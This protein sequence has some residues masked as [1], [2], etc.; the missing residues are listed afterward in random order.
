M[1]YKKADGTPDGTQAIWVAVKVKSDAD[2]IGNISFDTVHGN[3][4]NTH[5]N[6]TTADPASGQIIIKDTNNNDVTGWTFS[7]W[8]TESS[9]TYTDVTASDLAADLNDNNLDA[10][11]GTKDVNNV[12]AKITLADGSVVHTPVMKI[13]VLGGVGQETTYTHTTTAPNATDGV[14]NYTAVH[15]AFSGATYSWVEKGGTASAPTWSDFTDFNTRTED[16]DGNLAANDKVYVKI[17]WGDGTYQYVKAP[18][19][20][21]SDADDFAGSI[22]NAAGQDILSH[23]N[24]AVSD[25]VPGFGKISV[26]DASNNPLAENTNT[27]GALNGWKFAGWVTAAHTPATARD[28]DLSDADLTNGVKTVTAYAKIEL[29]DGS[30]VYSRDGLNIKVLGGYENS[31][32]TTTANG[33]SLTVDQAQTA[34]ANSSTLNTNFHASGA[35]QLTYA[36]ST[37]GIHTGTGYNPDVTYNANGTSAQRQQDRHAYVII[38]YGDGTTQAVKVGYKVRSDADDYTVAASGVSAITTHVGAAHLA[39]QLKG[40]ITLTHGTSTLALSS[41]TGAS[42]DWQNAGQTPSLTAASAE[43]DYNA[44]ITFADGSKSAAIAVPVTV[45]GI[46]GGSL[47][48]DSGEQPGTTN[49]IYESALNSTDLTAVHAGYTTT[50]TW[51]ANAEGDALGTTGYNTTW[52]SSHTSEPAYI[53]VSYTNGAGQADGAEVVKV[54][55]NLTSDADVYT[56][57]VNASGITTHVV[58][59]KD[60]SGSG[61]DPTIPEFSGR[62]I[63]N[64][65]SISGG[66]ATNAHDVISSITWGTDRGDKPDFSRTGSNENAYIVLHYTDGSTSDRLLLNVNVVGGAKRLNPDSS[67]YVTEIDEDT[68]YAKDAD[69]RTAQAALD[70]ATVRAITSYNADAKFSWAKDSEDESQLDTSYNEATASTNPANRN[71]YVIVTYHDGTKQAIEVPIKIKTDADRVTPSVEPTTPADSGFSV[72]ATGHLTTH[73]N[74]LASDLTPDKVITLKDANNNA[75]TLTQTADGKY[76]NTANHITDVKWNTAIDVASPHAEADHVITISF[77][78][79]TS[80]TQ[81]IPVTVLGFAGGGTTTV[82]SGQQPAATDAAFE[83]AMTSSD[84]TALS[85]INAA[86]FGTTYEWVANAN[87]DALGTT[88]YNTLYSSTHTTEPAYIKVTYHQGTGASAASDGSQVIAVTLDLSHRNTDYNVASVAGSSVTVHAVNVGTP[89][90]AQKMPYIFTNADKD[91]FQ[92]IVA[93]THASDGSAVASGDLA[94]LIDHIEWST[95]PDFTSLTNG[96]PQTAQAVIHFV[97][98]S[99]SD[100]FNI[101]VNVIGGEADNTVRTKI[102]R[103]ATAAAAANNEFKLDQNSDKAKAALTNASIAALTPT[104]GSYSYPVDSYTWAGDASDT[105]AVDTSWSAST[106]SSNPADRTAYVILHYHDGSKQ[107]VK[108]NIHINS[109]AERIASGDIT[110]QGDGIYQ[111]HVG[112]KINDTL[113]E[114]DNH[115]NVDLT[116]DIS[117]RDSDRNPMFV[118][119]SGN[120]TWTFA[121]FAS[122]VGSTYRP[123]NVDLDAADLTDGKHDITNLY[124]KLTLPDGSTTYVKMNHVY[125][126]GGYAHADDSDGTRFT[127]VNNGASLTAGQ[128][129]AAIANN[130][131]LTDASVVGSL[132]QATSFTWAKDTTGTALTAADTSWRAGDAVSNLNRTAYVIIGY[133][134]NTK[135]AVEDH[136]DVRKDAEMIDPTNTGRYNANRATY[137]T[138]VGANING[139]TN[140]GNVDLKNA[141]GF[142]DSADHTLFVDSSGNPTWTFAGFVKNTGTT[143]APVYAAADVDLDAADLTN[144]KNDITNLYAKVTL[145][146]G[147]I[148][149]VPLNHVYVYGGYEQKTVAGGVTTYPTATDNGT[150][151]TDDEARVAIANSGDLDTNFHATGAAHLTYQWSTGTASDPIVAPD[152]AYDANDPAHDSKLRTANVIITYGDGTKQAVQVHYNVNSDADSTHINIDPDDPAGKHI[153]GDPLLAHVVRSGG[154]EE[155][156]GADAIIVTVGSGSSAVTK[157]LGDI[158]ATIA[159]DTSA[160]MNTYVTSA[161]ETAEYKDATITYADHSTKAVQIRVKVV[162]ASRKLAIAAGVADVVTDHGVTPTAT[163]SINE[164]TVPTGTKWKI[165][166]VKWAD[167]S[168]NVLTGTDLT[169]FFKNNTDSASDI[170]VDGTTYHHAKLGYILVSYKRG[171]NADGSQLIAL[172][173]QIKFDADN[174]TGSIRVANGQTI[175]AHAN[176]AI[177]SLDPSAKLV[178]ADGNGNPLAENTSTTATLN[179]WKFIQWVKSAS[180]HATAT[181]RELDL[182][183]NNLDSNGERSVNGYAEIE[184]QDGSRIYSNSPLAIQVLGGVGQSKTYLHTTTAPQATDGV[185]NYTGVHDAFSGATYSWVENTGTVSSPTWVDFTDF[186]TRTHDR[187]GNLAANDKTYVKI[188]WGDGTYQYVKAP[189][190]I[191]NVTDEIAALANLKGKAL[192]VHVVNDGTTPTY[193]DNNTEFTYTD[194]SGNTQTKKLS[195]INADAALAWS[196]A[197]GATVPN[198]MQASG[199]TDY[200]AVITVRG[201]TTSVKVK[202]PVTIIGAS[203]KSIIPT[204]ESMHSLTDAETA[205]DLDLPNG[206]S[207]NATDPDKKITAS[208]IY[209]TPAADG[210]FTTHALD[211]SHQIDT[212]WS[213]T[214]ISADAWIKVQ[215]GSDTSH[216]QIVPVTLPLRSSSDG[217]TTALSSV[218]TNIATHVGAP[219]ANW[220]NST[221]TTAA[222]LGN[223][224][225]Y[226]HLTYGTGATATDV[227]LSSLGSA[228]SPIASIVWETKPDT[229]AAAD[230]AANKKAVI[231]ISFTDGSTAKEVEVP[232]TVVGA[233]AKS[234]IET[235]HGT[236]LTASDEIS[237]LS[238]LTTT[239]FQVAAS[240]ISWASDATG[241]ALP[242]DFWTTNSDSSTAVDPVSGTRITGKKG[243]YLLVHYKKA[244][245]TTADGSQAIW[246]AVKVKSDADN[247]GEVTVANSNTVTTHANAASLDPTNAITVSDTDG[248]NVTGWQFD[249]WATKDSLGHYHAETA[250]A[251]ATD[252]SDSGLDSTGL[253]DVTGRYAKIKLA[254]DS[255]VYTPAVTMHIVGGYSVAD[256]DAT[257]LDRG[258]NLTTDAAKTAA[259]NMIANNSALGTYHATYAWATGSDAPDVSASTSGNV[260]HAKVVI[261]YFKDAAHTEADGT[262]I[263]TVPYKVQDDTETHAPTVNSDGLTVHYGQQIGRG[264]AI[265]LIKLGDSTAY[266]TSSE[267]GRGQLVTNVQWVTSMTDDTAAAPNTLQATAGQGHTDVSSYIKVTYADGSSK[268][269][270]AT[271]HV[272]AGYNDPDQTYT[273]LSG[274]QPVIEQAKKA[275]KNSASGVSD[276][277][278]GY[279]VSYQ[280]AKDSAGTAMDDAY[281]TSST[282]VNK[283]AWVSHHLY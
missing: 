215:F 66:T 8:S 184:L 104:S 209:A 57:T 150:A 241:A 261:S 239:N 259:K 34:I 268:T 23:V 95:A 218:N 248:N 90:D 84:Q 280:W 112:A 155:V 61:P 267:V 234:D 58:N 111:T 102:N 29:Q 138:H 27:T 77:A 169:D 189:V 156:D 93:L 220:T 94:N 79:G 123:S 240:D 202:I 243:A 273:L 65:I 141:I 225:D 264:D 181:A 245:G 129:K 17:S 282:S 142:R 25:I 15:T 31:T 43:A 81:T 197:T 83:A 12:Y 175:Q 5:A 54:T 178:V 41:L 148:T 158:G 51:V 210:S 188:A 140:V 152:V 201:E 144:G 70:P 256:T 205:N 168:G 193:I 216:F 71:A 80:K 11:T 50:Y 279:N 147:S 196:T 68:V 37:D 154:T 87:G 217:I 137:T 126:Y 187:D 78:D 47:A 146:D 101:R 67:D 114:P 75:I 122:A 207:F 166:S 42:I 20:I 165:D 224:R 283:P 13:H 36:W 159:W 204:V 103:D 230:A 92:D 109:D 9:G 108:V 24:E 236:A 180:D 179:G 214:H 172:P 128:A 232:Y 190:T 274:T 4:V 153:S 52:S 125:V 44:V 194:D 7:G 255:V 63:D 200:D 247:V 271:V 116:R 30:Y 113:T 185:K 272:R 219:A 48:V 176:E 33:T 162:G 120:P 227:D 249:G 208:W 60:A 91:H 99:V 22:T 100:A 182:S 278:S 110:A 59:V 82:I 28:L 143:A 199:Q 258:E 167:A 157:T 69:E 85:S 121:G 195:E 151:L 226:V 1:H 161:H 244:D 221:G 250:A 173:V 191:E 277:L 160:D 133:A 16:S 38:T 171:T 45:L 96:T 206:Y 257:T 56:P 21:K 89:T 3:M 254:D 2:N 228:S 73:V 223:A 237:N 262:Q 229:S 251:L 32:E 49:T 72:N 55:L 97:G 242:S 238:D 222:T 105:T 269:V 39:D 233:N 177:S 263:V 186:N 270:A 275:I 64:L 252:L 18:V 86:G 231:K 10:T 281:V 118:D 266:L 127:K 107:A 139:P 131:T 276:S 115:R 203:A 192:T 40:A 124:A 135:Q 174:F 98:G 26:K 117:F 145:P 213:S 132:N 198:F 235:T 136:Y 19:T 134:D 35:T 163:D 211:S 130:A 164:P 265:G 119:A 46:R 14:A 246:V 76:V 62:D 53:K 212:K 183:D 253:K 260:H 106:D 74:A 88:G 149:Y 6:A 170:T